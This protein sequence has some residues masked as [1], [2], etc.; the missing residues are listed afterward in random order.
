MGRIDRYIKG[1][2]NFRA[3]GGFPE[4]FINLCSERKV[5]IQNVKLFKNTI[6]ASCGIKEYKKLKDISK[7]TGM[8]TRIFSKHGLPFFIH[9]K[10]EHVGILFGLC[11]MIIM[12]FFLTGRIWVIDVKGNEEIPTEEILSEFYSLGVKK[13]IKKDSLNVKE[14]ARKSLREIDD[15][16]WSAVNIDG[17]RITIEIKEQKK[18]EIEKEE[19]TYAN[20]VASNS[21]QIIKIESFQGT[22]VVK[23]TSA[24]EKGDVLISGAVINKDESVSF[25][26]AEGNVWANT[27]NEYHVNFS[28]VQ[29]M[30]IYSRAKKKYFVSFYSLTFPVNFIIGETDDMQFSFGE[31]FLSADNSKLP[32]SVRCERFAP[33]ETKKIKLTDSAVR[34]MCGR[35][36]FEEIIRSTTKDMEIKD[37]T[38]HVKVQKNVVE[39]YSHFNCLEN[40]AERKIMDLK[41]DN[42]E[43]TDENFDIKH[44]E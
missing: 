5:D 43:N 21:G 32:V 14:I 24:V 22:P 7:K 23:V 19:K 38:S 42:G 39:I 8:K 9:K 34:V 16:M 6:T 33:F 17:S 36:Y 4:R 3:I 44:N 27:E 18:K 30:R 25:Y 28:R 2:V 41:L 40:I 29:K 12:T 13:G 1:Y 20:L 15:I 37:E 31:K 26:N 11:F 10:R 35:K